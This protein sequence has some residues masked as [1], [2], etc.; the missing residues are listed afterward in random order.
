M[1]LLLFCKQF[2]NDVEQS[3]WFQSESKVVTIFY[4][5]PMLLEGTC[6]ER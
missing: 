2:G 1:Q 4:D 5:L 3:R 6:C